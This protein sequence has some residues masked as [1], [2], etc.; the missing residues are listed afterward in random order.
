MSNLVPVQDI[1]KMAL[2]V[3]KSGLFGVKTSEQAMALMLIAQAEGMHPAIAARDYHV[4]QG[5]PALKADA[6]MARFQASGGKVEWTTYTDQEVTGVF[7]HPAGG[8]VSITWSF[9]MASKIGLTGKDNWKN[10][11]RAMLR[12][13]VISEGIRTVYPGCVVGTYTP[14]EVQDFEPK[15]ANNSEIKDMGAAEIV[16]EIKAVEEI[17]PESLQKMKVDGENFLP[18]YIPD[19]EEPYA[20]AGNLAGWELS[21]H[22]LV[23]L[24]KN[25]KKLTDDSKRDKLKRLKEVNSEVME[26]LDTVTK[27]K[28]IAATNSLEEI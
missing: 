26:K 4:I 21:Y 7:S 17:T 13:R 23:A 6:M 8:S 16:E 2:A 27:M 20:I 9:A 24:I 15:K 28:V 10:Y 18:L 11:P 12:A 22:D 14:E 19:K 1:E 25:S 5:R 3:A